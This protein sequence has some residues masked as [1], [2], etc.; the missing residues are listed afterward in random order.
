MVGLLSGGGIWVFKWMIETAE[1]AWFEHAAAW[2]SQAGTWT[3]AVL[4]VTGGLVVGLI[5]HF[6]VGV[7][8]HHG[9]AGIIE[10]VALAG[11]RLRFWRMPAKSLAAAISIGSGASVGPEDPS[12]QIG[13]NLGSMIGQTLRLSDERVRTLVASGAAAG[14][15][16][17][18]NAPIAGV[19]FAIELILGEIGGS[20]LGVVVLSSVVSAVF[21]QAV[22][23]SQ[24]AF[25]I[26]AYAFHS[27]WELPLY[28][29]LG[30]LAGP[31]SAFYV[32]LIYRVQDVFHSWDIPVW[33][34]PAA[35]GLLVGICG[36]FLPQIFGVGYGTIES[37]L[38]GEPVGLLLLLALLAAKLVLTPVSVGGGFLGGVFAPA[39][40]LGATLGAAYA[41]VVGNLFPTLAVVPAAFAMVG[42]AAVLAGAVHAPLTAIL[43]LFE[44]TQDYR[45]I[46]PLMF[47]VVVSLVVSRRIER[48]SVYML[49]LARKGIRIDRGRDVE[50][51]ESIRVE[52][53]MQTNAPALN[54]SDSIEAASAR[55]MELRSHGLPVL[56]AFGELSGILS[57]RDIELALARDSEGLRVGEV[58]TRDLVVTYPDESLSQAL[59]RMSVR[60]IGRLPVV[61]REAPRRLIGILRRSDMI[62]AYDLALTRRAALRHRAQ[63]VR[64]GEAS[65]V[66]IEELVIQEGSACSGGRIREIDWPHES[67]IAT[68]RRGRR[69][70]LPH[71]D[72]ILHT[73][74]R[75]VVITEGK[76]LVRLREL[77]TQPVEPGSEEEREL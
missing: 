26:P 18:F 14:I 41:N 43:L 16:A 37:I 22:T 48:D 20:A 64:L 67:V 13:A 15:S 36:I 68:I 62:R 76:A 38:G 9:V 33:V 65:H 6:F 52:E 55:L 66:D 69:V 1:S 4:P 53:V 27:A 3:V 45:I 24:P 11:G 23:S 8:R 32:R 74:D 19:F 35:A 56:N 39:L 70:L 2:V 61:A 54:E 31:I 42:M 40:F 34:K 50:V 12:V 71:G 58:C 75:L 10:S 77:C 63:Q 47:A 59:Q 57:I 21:F 51:L 25:S 46:L 5:V 28:L 44:M 49:G 73:G 30:L 7:E 60:D 72:T 17:A 29:G